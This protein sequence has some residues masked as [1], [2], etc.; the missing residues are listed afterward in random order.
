[1]RFGMSLTGWLAAVLIF[2][3]GTILRAEGRGPSIQHSPMKSVLVNNSVVVRAR[4]VDAVRHVK[5]ATLFVALS[6]DATPFKIPMQLADDQ[7]YFGTIPSR[8][9]SKGA[10][11]TYYISAVNMLDAATETP[12]YVVEVLSGNEASDPAQEPATSWGKPVLLGLGG[13]AVVGGAA[14]AL[15]GG[16]GGG[17]GDDGGSMPTNYVGSYAGSVSSCVELSGQTP[18]C[19]TRGVNFTVTLQGVI[20]TDT[21]HEGQH[22]ESSVSG[23]DF[24]FV[25][26]SS[27]PGV[28][29]DVYY[30]GA[31]MDNRILGTVSGSGKQADGQAVTFSGSFEA[32]KN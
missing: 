27:D 2:G 8:V 23:N 16:G 32:V 7:T 21:L 14:L 15:G 26:P 1:M 10:S 31:I 3:T 18:A 28:T 11:F 25:A 4:I 29:G 17:G 19:T 20:V 30:Q 6:K 12:W 5:S 24:K 22:L 9:I 13:A